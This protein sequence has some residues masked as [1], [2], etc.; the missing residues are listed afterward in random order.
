MK[1]D[2]CEGTIPEGDARTHQNQTLC[3]DCYMDALATVKACDPWAVFAAK[4]T[5]ERQGDGAAMS[6]AQTAILETLDRH[7]PQ[8]PGTLMELL[9]ESGHPLQPG[10]LDRE[11]AALRHMEKISAELHNGERRIRRW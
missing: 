1:C 7:G 5:T 3:E 2:R 4:N 9:A 6:D 10:D 11:L 8:P